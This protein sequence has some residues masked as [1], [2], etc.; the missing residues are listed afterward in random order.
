MMVILKLFKNQLKLIYLSSI[1]LIRII[2]NLI[3]FQLHIQQ[4]IQL[5]LLFNLSYQV[6]LICYKLLK[7]LKILQ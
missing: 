4:Q 5:N 7:Y 3:P 6:I 1:S 2:I